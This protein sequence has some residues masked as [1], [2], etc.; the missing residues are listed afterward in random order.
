MSP[1][2]RVEVS[3]GDRNIFLIDTCP[4]FDICDGVWRVFSF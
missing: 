1:P 4:C 2:Y 3:V